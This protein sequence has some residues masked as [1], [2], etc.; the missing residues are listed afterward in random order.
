M[1]DKKSAVN[2]LQNSL[3]AN[4]KALA[5]CEHN[6]WNIQQLLM[7]YSPCDLELDKILQDIESGTD[8]KSIMVRYKAWK[9]KNLQS[10]FLNSNIKDDMKKSHL[11]I[12]PN[13]CSFDHLSSIDSKA[14]T[15]DISLNNAIPEII[16]IVDG[17]KPSGH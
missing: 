8:T 14:K 2:I 10:D 11:R 15:Y 3:I 9:S 4:E 5:I 16:S 17:Y 1:T 12:H 7:G 13:I 6:R